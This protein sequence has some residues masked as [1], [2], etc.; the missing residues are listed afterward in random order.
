MSEE[1]E[2]F[3]DDAKDKMEKT[4]KHLDGELVKIRAG[5]ANPHMLDGIYINYYGVNTPLHQASNINAPDPK[6][7]TIQP[8]D[9]SVIET[10]VK[11]IMAANLGLHPMVQGEIIRISVPPLSEERRRILVKQV[12][13]EGENAKVITR[14]IRRETNDELKKLKKEGVSEDDIKEGEEK[15]Q[16]LTDQY[17]KKVDEMLEK[18]EKDI[19]TI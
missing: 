10:I 4:L 15:V 13:N 1:V 6:T 5:K 11:A 14:N 3:L 19:M 8:W 2:M 16:K 7:L 18:K 12:K 9:R 17:I